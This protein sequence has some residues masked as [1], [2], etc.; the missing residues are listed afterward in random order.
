MRGRRE[1]ALHAVRTSQCAGH[2][3]SILTPRNVESQVC[4]NPHTLL[5]FA[6]H[7]TAGINRFRQ[8]CKTYQFI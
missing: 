2:T 6:D 3:V 1:T 5:Q 8:P 7:L 4:D